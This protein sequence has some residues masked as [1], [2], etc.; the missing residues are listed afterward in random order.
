MKCPNCDYKNGWDWN[1]D[2]QHVETKGKDGD[3]Y[4]LPIKVERTENIFDTKTAR[5][6]ACPSCKVVFIDDLGF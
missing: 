6:H 4:T 1:D 5:V 2:D 3:F